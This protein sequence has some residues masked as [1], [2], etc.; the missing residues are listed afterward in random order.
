MRDRDNIFE[1]QLTADKGK[2]K[3]LN[4]IS[5][6]YKEIVTTAKIAN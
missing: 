1:L 3:G 2:Q 4:M 5:F 6:W